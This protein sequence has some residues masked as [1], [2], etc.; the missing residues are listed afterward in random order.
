M[1]NRTMGPEDR[2]QQSVFEWAQWMQA[3]YPE[4]EYMY[5]VPNGGYRHK[6]TAC[7]LKLTGVKPGVPDICLP[8]AHGKYHGLYVEMKAK[9]GTESEF[10]KKYIKYLNSAGYLAVTCWGNHEATDT[11]ERYLRM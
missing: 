6:A 2:A 1:A 3:Q 5:A 7:I 11:I 4:L 9:G 10:Q 8:A